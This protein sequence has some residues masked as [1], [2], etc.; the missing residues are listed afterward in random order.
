[1]IS[2]IHGMGTDIIS[3][4]RMNRLL[5]TRNGQ[6]WFTDAE[7]AYCSSKAHP[8]NHYAARLAAKEAAFKSLGL[9]S[10]APVPWGL[11]EVT[12]DDQ[13]LPR[14]TFSGWMADEVRSLGIDEVRISMSHC[15]EFAVA[16]AI[17]MA[18]SANS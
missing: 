11:M 14:M 4:Q 16:T 5:G 3:V 7:V 6:R 13:G 17:A 9:N 18:A 10:D 8:A 15:D 12:H 1:M 2:V